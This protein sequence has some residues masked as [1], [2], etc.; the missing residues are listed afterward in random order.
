M[1]LWEV[2]TNKN[3]VLSGA[4]PT[5]S[6]VDFLNVVLR[7]DTHGGEGLLTAGSAGVTGIWPGCKSGHSAHVEDAVATSEVSGRYSEGRSTSWRVGGLCLVMGDIGQM[8]SVLARG[9]S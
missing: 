3:N 7:Y 6:S 9:T 4:W 5:I 1:R 2:E 8:R